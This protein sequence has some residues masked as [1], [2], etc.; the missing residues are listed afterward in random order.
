MRK[1]SSFGRLCPKYRCSGV[2]ANVCVVAAAVA[3]A[4]ARRQEREQRESLPTYTH[5][6]PYLLVLLPIIFTL[7]YTLFS[8]VYGSLNQLLC[9]LVIDRNRLIL[10]IGKTMQ[11][12]EAPPRLLIKY[13]RF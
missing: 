11:C 6:Y 7:I 3:G 1:Q 9:H 5:P 13:C 4:R 12:W 8:T 10:L 2:L